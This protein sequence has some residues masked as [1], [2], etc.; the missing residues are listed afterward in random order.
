METNHVALG[1]KCKYYAG[2]DEGFEDEIERE[3]IRE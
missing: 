3:R 2:E 1:K